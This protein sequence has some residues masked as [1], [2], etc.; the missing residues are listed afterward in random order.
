[1][2]SKRGLKMNS[3]LIPPKT[4]GWVSYKCL[5]EKL[6]DELVKQQ[7]KHIQ[8]EVMDLLWRNGKFIGKDRQ[9]GRVMIPLDAGCRRGVQMLDFRV[10]LIFDQTKNRDEFGLLIELER[11]VGPTGD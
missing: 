7:Y 5:P 2:L 10:E 3:L 9:K 8:F 4:E 1:M 6:E 11:G